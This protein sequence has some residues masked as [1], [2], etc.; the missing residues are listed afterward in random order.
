VKLLYFDCISGISGDMALGAFIDAGVDPDDLRSGL[1]ALPVEPWSL[2]T[3]QVETHGIRAIRATVRAEPSGVIRTYA[4]IRAMLDEAGLPDA[5]RSLAQ[6]MFR[7]LAEAEAR[8]HG[9]DIEQVAFHEVGA[10][11]SIV[12]ITG[13]A[14]AMSLLDVERAFSSPVPTG[15]GMVK[16]EH[17]SMPIPAPAVV[18][19]LRGA[20]IF[21]G[22]VPMELV[23]PTG[24]AILATT[25]EGFGELPLLAIDAV[26]YGAGTLR[27]D[28]ANVLRVL[29][30]EGSGA[31][32][33]E[34]DRP[35]PALIAD[36][37]TA[38]L[39]T[40][41]DDLSPELAAHVIEQLLAAG[42]Q[43]AW[44]TPIV[45]KKG[46]P[47]V[48]VSVLCGSD[49]AEALRQLLFRETGT[50]GVRSHGV[51]KRTLEREWVEVQT[52]VG[53]VRVKV[54]RLEGRPVSVAPEYE[55]CASIARDAG[56]PAREIYDEA[57][58]LAREVLQRPE[59]SE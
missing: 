31:A 13:V 35:G 44:L 29:I 49:R 18:E 40:N 16:T 5:A 27:P 24:A 56:V 45:M 9:R 57:V 20:P 33:A 52:S 12:D 3:Q 50:L 46:R 59:G 6:R 39:E 32:P 54:G 8:V 2:E 51:D 43:D 11:D 47:A 19:L 23:T 55:D 34:S 21:S 4:G 15:L 53:A 58:R 48:T 30:G 14:L 22:G 38:V 26:G 37:G 28:F 17:G 42:A 7:R 36:D 1:A 10:V 25:V 41:V